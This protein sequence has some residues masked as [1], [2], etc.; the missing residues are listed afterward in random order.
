MTSQKAQ[1][2]LAR[3]H[4]YPREGIRHTHYPIRPSYFRHCS[5]VMRAMHVAFQEA[6]TKD[7]Q[8]YESNANL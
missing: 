1:A 7:E 8:E 2:R 6:K 3:V 4:L 5:C